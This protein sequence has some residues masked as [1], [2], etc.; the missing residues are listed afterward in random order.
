MNGTDMQVGADPTFDDPIRALATGTSRRTA[1]RGLAAGLLAA[2]G[3]GMATDTVAKQKRK[4]KK[5]KPKPKPTPPTTPPPTTPLPTRCPQGTSVA[6]LSV[7]SDGSQSF[8]PVLEEG[9]VYILRASGS[10]S[11][12]GDY[13]CDAFA[14]FLWKDPRSPVLYHNG[15]RL[16]L[17]IDGLSP[18]HWGSY[19]QSHRY[20]FS[21]IG[22]GQPVALQML[23]SVYSDNGRHL[24]VDVLCGAPSRD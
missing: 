16:G 6:Y 7:P 12:N 17:A 11:T 4:R 18:D 15:V 22:K 14:A 13:M 24:Y 10:W 9:Q 21:V 19:N 2:A 3:G 1:L 23:D 8:T 20:S 5:G